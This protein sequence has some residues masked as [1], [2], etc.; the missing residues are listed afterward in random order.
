MDYPARPNFNALVTDKEKYA[1]WGELKFKKAPID[2]NPEN[3]IITN[4]YKANLIQV[5]IPQ[6]VGIPGAPKSGTVT[7]HK[8]AA[9]QL[10][11]AFQLIENEGLLSSLTSYD[12][13]FCPR[14]IRGGNSLSNHAFG[15]AIDLS[16]KWNGLG[17]SPPAPPAKGSVWKIVHCFNACGFFWG[18]HYQNR[19]DGMHFEAVLDLSY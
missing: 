4:E 2:G 18:G 11:M 12:G 16:A 7:F 1:M 6:L 10:L 19:K 3:I 5:V 8:K 15:T 9:D 17:I 13:T 14:L